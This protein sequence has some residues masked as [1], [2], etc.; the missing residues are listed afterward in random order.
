M[1]TSRSVRDLAVPSLVRVS[2][3]NRHYGNRWGKKVDIYRAPPTA[4][5]VADKGSI[6][7]LAPQLVNLKTPRDAAV[8]KPGGGGG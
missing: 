6:P 3:P 8:A 7:T 4:N 1:T 2:G 5:P